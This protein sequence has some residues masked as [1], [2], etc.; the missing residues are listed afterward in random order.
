[1]LVFGIDIPLIELLIAGII[2]SLILL[3]EVIVVLILTLKVYD[4]AKKISGHTESSSLLDL[5]KR[6]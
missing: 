5:F 3:I 2:I 1:M 6:K 4:K